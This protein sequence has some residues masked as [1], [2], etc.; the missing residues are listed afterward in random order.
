MASHIGPASSLAQETRLLD[1]ISDI[2][3]LSPQQADQR[4]PIRLEAQVIRINPIF[5][6]LFI[7][8]GKSGIFVQ[9]RKDDPTVKT[10]QTGDRVLVQGVSTAGGFSPDIAAETIQITGH[11]PLPPA[12]PLLDNERLSPRID[13][14]WVMIRGRLMD[15][16]IR[17]Q[18]ETIV[19]EVNQNDNVL[20]VQVPYSAYNEKELA[21][22]M[23]NLVQF[24]AVAGTVFNDNRQAIGRVLFANSADDFMPNQFSQKFDTEKPLQVHEL[25]RY[26][27]SH[28]QTTKTGG[29]VTYA[30]GREMYLRGERAS[31]K[32][33][34]PPDT[35]VSIGDEVIVTGVPWPQPVSPA[36]RA[37]SVQ[38]ISHHAHPRPIR[39]ELTGMIASK[40]NYE[41]IE[42]DADLVESGKR[43]DVYGKKQ[44]TL[45]C[46]S[47]EQLFEVRYPPDLIT[48]PSLQPGSR[49]RLTGICNIVRGSSRR[50]YLDTE[51]FW[52]QLRE[53]TDVSVLV[54]PPWMTHQRMLWMSALTLGIAV[55]ALSWVVILRKTVDRQTAVIGDQVERESVMKERQRIAREL[56]DNLMQGLVGMAIQLRGCFRGLELNKERVTR[57]IQESSTPEQILP[58]V[59][60]WAEKANHSLQVLHEMLNQ[61]SEES[62][63]SILYLRSG[64]SGRMGLLS[65]LEEVLEPLAEESDVTLAIKVNG[66]S[67]A[68]QQEMERNLMLVIKE[69]VTNAIRHA[70][71]TE[72]A[73][74]L[75]YLTQGISIQITDN[76]IGFD[77]NRPPEK[78]HYGMQGMTE[79]IHQLGGTLNIE[80]EQKNGT[81]V[82]IKIDS[83]AEWEISQ[84]G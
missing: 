66:E 5:N 35:N 48:P 6:N 8:D 15:M 23:F 44:R 9:A 29:M 20:D 69:A 38:V 17:D 53:T 26:D 84:D 59:D 14:A 65:A 32:V 16:T 60:E 83:T 51:G 81:I 67:R 40:L 3:K 30:G 22:K 72:I 79:R 82:S 12:L 49:L 25:M 74:V 7:Y 11:Q 41:L 54:P 45:L 73:V 70:A 52:L 77:Q 71:P 18:H 47:A 10:L 75:N 42:I 63:S 46:R 28:R 68:L 39:L 34:L 55:L 76:G 43:F 24:N 31:L 37:R 80:S 4:L 58:A 19:L 57:L 56:H 50:W 2:R 61:C 62:R 27:L 21:Q 78:G 64:M 33:T 36:L 1:T 13:C